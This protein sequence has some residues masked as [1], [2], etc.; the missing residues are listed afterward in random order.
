MAHSNVITCIEL[1]PAMASMSDIEC[2]YTIQS[3]KFDNRDIHVVDMVKSSK[4]C[5]SS[6]QSMCIRLLLSHK[7]IILKIA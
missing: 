1:H 7:G 5:Q 6:L 4:L 2:V 3:W